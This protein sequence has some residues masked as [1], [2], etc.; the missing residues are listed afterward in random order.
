[1]EN[2]DYAPRSEF[3]LKRKGWALGESKREIILIK[4]QRRCGKVVF[5]QAGTYLNALT[6]FKRK[7]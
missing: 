5:R 2:V 7:M 1:M 6:V 4:K 3:K